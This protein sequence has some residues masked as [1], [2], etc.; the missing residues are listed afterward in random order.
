MPLSR[1]TPSRGGRPPRK[2]LSE[3][4]QRL[5]GLQR[6]LEHLIDGGA[7]SMTQG[8]GSIKK[9]SLLLLRYLGLG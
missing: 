9:G 8:D 6:V 2:Q 1:G 5:S 7:N 4:L 3:L